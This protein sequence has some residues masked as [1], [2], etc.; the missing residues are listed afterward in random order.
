MDEKLLWYYPI[1]REGD[2]GQV[3][4][5]TAIGRFKFKCVCWEFDVVVVALSNELPNTDR[6]CP[7]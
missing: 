7:G 4:V 2:A 1:E 5:P 6:Y 3:A